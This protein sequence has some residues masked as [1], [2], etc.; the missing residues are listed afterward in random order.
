MVLNRFFFVNIK[1]KSQKP[2]FHCDAKYLASGVGVGQCTRR[3]NFALPNVKYTNMFF[4]L[5][6]FATGSRRK[7]SFQWNMGLKSICTDRCWWY[8]STMFYIERRPSQF[9]ETS[10][11]VTN[12]VTVKPIFYKNAN[13][14]AL[15]PHIRHNPQCKTFALPIPTCWY[16]KKPQ[17]PNATP[18]VH[19]TFFFYITLPLL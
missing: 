10:A 3:Q 11:Q 9:C 1:S 14:L 5:I 18:N 17:G 7:H 16:L 2:I 8:R 13:P 15:G 4:V 6:S 12:C 19:V